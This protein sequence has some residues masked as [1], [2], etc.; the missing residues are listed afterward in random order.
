MG[1][2]SR[3]SRWKRLRQGS[4]LVIAA[5]ATVVLFWEG[6][7]EKKNI[8]LI[9]R[10]FELGPRQRAGVPADHCGGAQ[11]WQVFVAVGRLGRTV[12]LGVIW[13]DGSALL[14]RAK[15]DV[16]SASDV[17]VHASESERH[18]SCNSR[19]HV[20]RDPDFREPWLLHDPRVEAEAVVEVGSSYV[21]RG[22]RF[23]SGW[24]V[25][26]PRENLGLRKAGAM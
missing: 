21:E 14:T 19:V 15:P 10:A 18:G 11:R 3:P 8:H 23:R 26:K 12:R 16:F 20:L 22:V 24:P 6:I 7:N 17:F 2:R 9:I 25:R 4:D 13:C 5:D 1:S